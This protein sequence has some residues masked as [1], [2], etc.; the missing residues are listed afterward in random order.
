MGSTI[1][2]DQVPTITSKVVQYN[3]DEYKTNTCTVYAAMWSWTATTGIEIPKAKRIEIVDE[4]I[5]RWLDIN[6]WRWVHSAVKLVYDMMWEVSFVSVS[7]WSDDYFEAL[8]RGYH[9]VAWYNGNRIYNTDRDNNGIVEINN[10]GKTSY[11]HCIRHTNYD[12]R[13]VDNYPARKTNLYELPNIQQKMKVWWQIF[14]NTYFYIPKIIIPMN[15]LPA[16]K[17]ADQV[18]SQDDK[19]IITAWENEVSKW[20]TDWGDKSKLWR[21]Y[22][23]DRAVDRM[24]I[25][26]WY[27]RRK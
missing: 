1:D 15:N 5:K 18:T 3:Q 19:A 23:W 20:L 22:T 21:D 25:D 11:W 24:L 13:V 8:K 17:T 10:R 14:Y 6:I 2:R 12:T 7:T 9:L 4:A 26:L 16:H 27:I